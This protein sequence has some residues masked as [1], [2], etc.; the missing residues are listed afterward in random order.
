MITGIYKIINIKTGKYYLGSSQ[1][2]EK[3]IARHFN[4]L[5]KNKHHSI[6]FQRSYNKHSIHS[7]V[8]IVVEKCNKK[9]LFDLEQKYL[10][11]IDFKHSY[12]V[13]KQASGGDLLSCHPNKESIIKKRTNTINKKFALMTRKELQDKYGMYGKDNPNWR[14][15]TRTVCPVCSKITGYAKVKTC[16]DCQVRTGKNNPFY[17][18]THTAETKAKISNT[19]K[20]KIYKLPSN[21]RK[22]SINGIEYISVTYSAK[23]LNVAVGTIVHRIK[24]P[25]PKF[26]N[27][28]YID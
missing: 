12:N 20:S 21:T 16:S 25:N 5:S 3:R 27:Y 14:G 4:D 22:V 24:S 15:D 13:S 26:K 17:G 6:Y 23:C 2:V 8:Y 7:F 10:D 28:L 19:K 1:N 11:G 9:D 18:K